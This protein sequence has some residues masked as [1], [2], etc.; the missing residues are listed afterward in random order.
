LGH[1][2]PIKISAPLDEKVWTCGVEVDILLDSYRLF[3]L[4][5]LPSRIPLATIRQRCVMFVNHASPAFDIIKVE[6]RRLRRKYPMSASS[7]KEAV[8][9]RSWLFSTPEL[10]YISAPFILTTLQ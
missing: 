1:K 10:V 3:F 9:T 7:L 8:D 5:F 6:H 4:T 2:S